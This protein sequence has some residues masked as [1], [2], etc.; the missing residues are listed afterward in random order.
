VRFWEAGYCWR[1]PKQRTYEFYRVS[2]VSRF[3]LVVTPVY[4][5]T[6]DTRKISLRRSGEEK[7]S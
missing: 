4:R 2:S 6:E 7:A 3:G 5:L 1:F